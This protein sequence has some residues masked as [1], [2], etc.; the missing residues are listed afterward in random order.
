MQN[1]VQNAAP[2]AMQ[3]VMRA[4]AIVKRYPGTVA[5]KDVDFTVWPGM[6][7]VLVGENGAGKSTLMKILSGIER[8]DAGSVTLEGREV[9]FAST[10][11]ASGMG[12][13]IIHQELN[14][15]PDMRVADNM[16]AGKELRRHGMIDRKAQVMRA[17][18]VLER[19]QQ[20]ID[21]NDMMR[22]LRVGQQ[23]VVEIAK[24]M[25]Q[26]KLRVLIMDEPTSSLSSAEVEVLF[27]LI[28]DLKRQGIALIYISHRLEEIVRIG[29]RITVLRDGSKIDEADVAGIDVPWI[30]QRMVGHSNLNIEKTPYPGEA[31]PLLEVRDYTLPRLGG[32]YTVDHVGFT[33]HKGEV[34][35][36]YGLMG[37]GRTELAE[38]IM[39][40]HPESRGELIVDGEAVTKPAVSEQIAR[41]LVLVPEDRQ[42]DGLVQTMSIASNLLL[43]CIPRLTKPRHVINERACRQA[44]RK[45][46]EALQVKTAD[47]RHPVTALSGGNQ[48]KVVIGKCVL[49]DAKIFLMDE[50][51]RGIDVGAKT[52]IFCLMRQF[53]AEGKGVLFMGSE[54]KEILSVCDRVLVLSNG[55]LTADLSGEALI[56]EALVAASAANL[57]TG[58]AAVAQVEP[59]NTQV[60][61]Q[62]FEEDQP[63]E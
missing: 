37:A 48:Q 51:S 56:E 14:L 19:L 42:K 28:A 50:P 23:Q 7:N 33:L 24:T 54:L 21:P 5:L 43:T 32:G 62:K 1:A 61:I 59:V 30:V 12:V 11:E 49:A 27:K 26:Q 53:A 22:N 58:K 39:G 57:K 4:E 38:C 46:I 2:T 52:D 6:V 40:L 17:K 63:N 10:R 47:P 60:C 35:G 25:L 8:P 41:G 16:F 3:P 9:H 55:K 45:A 13:G 31:A 20:D 29:D 18:E 44:V 36:L 34:L 15:F